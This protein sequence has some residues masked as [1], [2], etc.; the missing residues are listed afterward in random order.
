[1][2]SAWKTSPNRKLQP[3]EE[4]IPTFFKNKPSLYEN[5]RHGGEEIVRPFSIS[6][7]LIKSG[8]NYL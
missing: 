7:N 8:M 5:G 4:L 2:K 1:M 6:N 3:Y